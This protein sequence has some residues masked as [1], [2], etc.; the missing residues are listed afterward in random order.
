M[1]KELKL[2][3]QFGK[4]FKGTYV[5]KAISWAV[6]NRI[7]S[8]C[9]QLNPITRQTS[10]DLKKLQAMTLDAS[11]VKRPSNVTLT[12]LE[13]ENT[14]TGLPL[15][16]GELLMAMADKVNG[17][18]QEDRENLKKLKRQWGLE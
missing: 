18:G 12:M 9:T 4:Q 14:E 17:Y 7:T 3:E 2:D 15:A 10:I 5:F 16:L 6:S 8:E 13:D 11:M 1:E